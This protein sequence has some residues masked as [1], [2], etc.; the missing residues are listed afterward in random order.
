[1]NSV[2]SHENGNVVA[3]WVQR[4]RF[5]RS[6]RIARISPDELNGQLAAGDKPLIVDLRSTVDVKLTPYAL[7]GAVRLATEDV[8]HG[9]VELP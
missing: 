2:G 1:L 4:Q 8:E 6:L 7:P 5:L 9:R 3:K